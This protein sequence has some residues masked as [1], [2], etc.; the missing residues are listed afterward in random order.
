LFAYRKTL[1]DTETTKYSFLIREALTDTERCN[2]MQT[3]HA[4]KRRK[5]I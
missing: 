2:I 1:A 4:S 3:K 5:G